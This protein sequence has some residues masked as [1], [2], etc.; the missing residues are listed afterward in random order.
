MKCKASLAMV[1]SP[2]AEVVYHSLDSGSWIESDYYSSSSPLMHASLKT[3]VFV[4]AVGAGAPGHK[5]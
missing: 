3:E 5:V 2:A 1:R 4:S